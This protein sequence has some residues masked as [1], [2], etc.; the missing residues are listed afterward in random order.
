MSVLALF[1]KFTIFALNH[2]LFQ[3][4][5]T[6]AEQLT[7]ELWPMVSLETEDTFIDPCPGIYWCRK[8]YMMKTG[9]VPGKF[10]RFHAGSALFA[11]PSENH[12]VLRNH[13]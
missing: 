4:T 9:K 7:H 12:I 3:G 6:P 10:L 13:R 11:H 8:C 2:V 5:D 1:M